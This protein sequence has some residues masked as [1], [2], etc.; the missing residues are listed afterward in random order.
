MSYIAI[1]RENA[2]AFEASNILV[3]ILRIDRDF[4]PSCH[5]SLKNIIGQIVLEVGAM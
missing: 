4:V 3:E 1:Y 2:N 5:G